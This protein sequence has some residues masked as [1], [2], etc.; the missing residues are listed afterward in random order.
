MKVSREPRPFEPVVLT[1]ENEAEVRLFIGL[2][3]ALPT[4]VAN[5]GAGGN[6]NVDKM[7]KDLIRVSG[8]SNWHAFEI[9]RPRASRR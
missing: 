7:H 4:A 8:L 3:S 1:L 9:I 5:N 6:V 2:L